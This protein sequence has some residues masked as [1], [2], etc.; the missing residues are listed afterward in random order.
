M[1]IV[2]VSPLRFTE[3]TSKLQANVSG[4]IVCVDV[5]QMTSLKC[6]R[7]KTVSIPFPTANA[8]SVP[9]YVKLDLFA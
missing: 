8:L 9:V 3:N 5:N 1:V 4:Y 6:D 7:V 2:T